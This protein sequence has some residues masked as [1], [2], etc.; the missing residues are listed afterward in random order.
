MALIV[1]TLAVLSAGGII[2]DVINR[3][4]FYKLIQTKKFRNLAIISGEPDVDSMYVLFKT[5]YITKQTIRHYLIDDNI[6]LNYYEFIATTKKS[7]IDSHPKSK[8]E[9][10][11]LLFDPDLE[12]DDRLIT[13]QT[14][15]ENQ[16]VIKYDVPKQTYCFFGEITGNNF[17]T[18]CMGS[19]EFVESNVKTHFGINSTLTTIISTVFVVSL[20]CYFV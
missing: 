19:K 2:Y 3:Y 20:A 11:N 18:K 15:D 6:P 5:T 10:Y 1:Q 12:I 9:N 4:K 7:D 17:V 14:V 13:S 8:L 16:T